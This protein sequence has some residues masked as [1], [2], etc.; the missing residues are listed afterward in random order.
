MSGG[1]SKGLE[2]SLVIF[3]PL[4]SLMLAHKHL[5]SLS[6]PRELAVENPVHKMS[7]WALPRYLHR[8]RKKINTHFSL[9]FTS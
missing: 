6:L 5:Y 9:S 3:H 2:I 4:L 8:V 7:E 1:C